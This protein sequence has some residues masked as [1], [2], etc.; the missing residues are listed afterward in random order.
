[1]DQRENKEE[2]NA[3]DQEEEENQEEENAND[4]EEEENKEEENKDK[5]TKENKSEGENVEVKT[6]SSIIKAGDS[7]P[8]ITKKNLT[9]HSKAGSILSK[10]AKLNQLDSLRKLVV[11]AALLI[12]LTI[13]ALL[14]L[15][16]KKFISLI[17]R[18]DTFIKKKKKKGKSNIK[19][20]SKNGLNTTKKGANKITNNTK[21][22]YQ[23]IKNKVKK[24][25][26]V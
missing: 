15:L 7:L 11:G 22:R 21:K 10:V 19:N 13:A 12:P 26:K 8:S 3:N 1:M 4:Q 9:G 18:G 24:K 5:N 23:K 16:F 17:K 2:E 25:Q 6:H 14:A 20:S